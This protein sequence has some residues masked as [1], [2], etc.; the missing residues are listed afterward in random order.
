MVYLI[1][2]FFIGGAGLLIYMYMEAFADRVLY[3]ELSF[4][5]FPDSFGEV[6]LFFI[7]DI[8]RRLISEKMIDEVKEKK[9][10]MVIIGGDLLEKGVSFEKVKKNVLLLMKAA[11]VYFVW[12]NNDYEVDYHELDALL[13]E[14]GV[15]ILDNTALSFESPVGDKFVLMGTDDLSKDR[16]RLDLALSDA[17][18]SGFRVLV[19]HDPRIVNEIE[20]EHNIHLVL[21]GHTHGGQI[22][23]L[24]YSPYEKGRVKVLPQ[25]TIL[26]S[27]GY[28]TTGVPLRLGAKAETHFITI[29]FG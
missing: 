22:H 13:V 24:G 2:L 18:L 4:S 3:K 17:G 26:I 16:D 23:I 21:S 5:E 6:K 7:S 14:C 28:G 15:K 25:T 29:K 1:A 12:G 9:P 8:H 19:S 20:K 27:N 10:D 11:P